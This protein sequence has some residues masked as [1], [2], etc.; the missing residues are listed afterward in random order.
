MDYNNYPNK[1]NL[2][3]SWWCMAAEWRSKSQHHSQSYVWEINCKFQETRNHLKSIDTWSHPQLIL[4]GSC[5]IGLRLLRGFGLRKW[6][7]RCSAEF[8]SRLTFWFRGLFIRFA[9]LVIIYEWF[10]TFYLQTYLF[11]WVWL[12]ANKE[13][14]W[15]WKKTLKTI[16][17]I[18]C[19]NQQNIT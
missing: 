6:R 2:H 8:L 16:I 18:T 10:Y 3:G 12:T 15:L 7:N 11:N 13:C 5:C 14:Y 1:F 19:R 9:W 17:P 4:V